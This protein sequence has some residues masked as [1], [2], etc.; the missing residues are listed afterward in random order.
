MNAFKRLLFVLLAVGFVGA[1]RHSPEPMIFVASTPCDGIPRTMLS[2]PTQAP[3]EFITWTLTLQRDPR[4]QA[5]TAYRLRY[6]YGMSKPG[7]QGFLDGGTP[8]TKEGKWAILK[9]TGNRE[10]YRLDPDTPETAISF[11]KLDDNLLHLLDPQGKLLI[12]HAGWSYT[13]NRKR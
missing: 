1:N 5:P 13:L 8:A 12:G 6:T 7:T 3:C 2:I 9:G 11:T 4:N 10:T